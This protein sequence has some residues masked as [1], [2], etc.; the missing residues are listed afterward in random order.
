MATTPSYTLLKTILVL[1]T[2]TKHVLTY[3]DLY[4]M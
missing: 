1:M 4:H 2:F 3:I